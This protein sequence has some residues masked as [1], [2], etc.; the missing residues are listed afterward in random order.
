[1]NGGAVIELRSPV[2]LARDLMKLDQPAFCPS[3]TTSV[4]GGW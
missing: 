2:M 4:P 3:G 1:M